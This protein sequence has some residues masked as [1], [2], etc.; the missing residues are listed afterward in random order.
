MFPNRGMKGESVVT[1]AILPLRFATSTVARAAI[2]LTAPLL[3]C[4][5]AAAFEEAQTAAGRNVDKAATDFFEQHVRPLFTA[6]CVE[7]H[8]GSEAEAGLRL[9][10]AMALTEGADTG[11]VVV[12]G[13]PDK[14]RLIEV[15]RYSGD[16]QMP[17]TEK[18]PQEQI[19]LLEEWVRKGAIWP[20]DT[21]AAPSTD[22]AMD[23]DDGPLG[24]A[25]YEKTKA[26]HWSLQP[27]TRPD[28]P[29][30]DG[31]D[32]PQSTIDRFVL[33]SLE[34]VGLTP[35]ARAD[36]RTL[37]RRLYFDVVGLPPS[38]D[39]VDAFIADDSPLA[40]ERVINRLLNSPHYGQRWGR[41]WL[42]VARYADTKGYA[43]QQE[44][45]YPFAYTYRDYV[46]RALNQ[47]LPFDRFIVEQIAA[48]LLL[49]EQQIKDHTSLAALGFLTVG[50]RFNFNV[51]DIIDDRIDVVTRGFMG[52]SVS[53]ARCHDHKYDPVPTADYYSLYG[54]FASSHEP[55]ELPLI[56][57]PAETEAYAAYV[58]ELK[59]REGAVGE[60]ENKKRQQIEQ[61][62]R[63]QVT[64][65][66]LNVVA[67]RQESLDDKSLS[68][69]AD[70]LRPSVLKGWRAYLKKRTKADDPVFG[71]WSY[72]AD[73][74]A[75]E[76][77][78]G[79][80][81]LFAN[82]VESDES[83][84]AAKTN[85][86]V[87]EHFR[88]ARPADMADVA[89]GYG[90]LLTDVDNRWTAA[91]EQFEAQR[92]A[93][94]EATPPTTLEDAA[95]EEMRQVLY[96]DNSP[97]RVSSDRLAGVLDRA[98][99][100][101]LRQLKKEVE[102]WKADSPA[103][104]A[105]AMVLVDN[106]KPVEPHVFLRGS[107]GRRGDQVTR[108]FLS[109]LGD[110]EV[111]PFKKG[112]G[113]LELAR[114]IASRDN[115]LTARVIVNRVWQQYFGKGLVRTSSDFGTRGELPS[116]PELLD[117]L[118]TALVDN[119][120]SLKW[121]HGQILNSATYQQASLDREA[122]LAADP[123]NRLLW[124]MNRKPLEFEP[125]RDAMLLVSGDLVRRVGGRSMNLLA[126]EPD[127]YRRAIYGFIDRQDLPNLLRAFNFASP[128]AS[129]AQRPTT[130]VPQQALF[131]MNSP[132]V[133]QRARRAVADCNLDDVSSDLH[134]AVVRLFRRI[135][136]R[137]PSPTEIGAAE[138]F[139]ASAH[140]EA[141]EGVEEPADPAVDP[142]QALSVWERLAQA[143]LMTNEFAFV[144]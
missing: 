34:N 122:C 110:P 139:V 130:V 138:L 8:A 89:R 40:V 36:R 109:A 22:V 45:R 78:A 79:A 76:F 17:P 6:H 70:D 134:E 81:R 73:L 23:P 117:H 66:L 104:P 75:D 105:R 71:L 28:V 39:E 48:D 52:L 108:H 65:Y 30:V 94:P 144:D 13:D 63:G 103:A 42:D 62:L 120:W 10:G 60:Y 135:L 14:S 77:A 74:P 129:E 85:K 86:L 46:I 126:L 142:A 114:A 35:S 80:E 95:A 18:L 56:A 64:Q 20:T 87:W 96:A 16:I 57:P 1:A 140:S 112:S 44:P 111:S 99:R 32:W 116:H 5:R 131:M 31:A 101:K 136:G 29:E 83:G 25:T 93:S 92:S 121:L 21:S 38:A 37:L 123:E 118:A 11:P 125:L 84:I 88:D 53:C 3:W 119:G 4:D 9:D 51:H 141:P 132:F 49:E 50:R 68:L 59:R 100:N 102:K 41:H 128:D 98:D 127:S 12:V 113:R 27:I 15:V 124:K 106:D 2:L 55:N 33:A 72:F 137:T 54:V 67:G 69:G 58:E 24:P 26:T 143:L 19:A 43:F 133:I 7:C 107:P 90:Q 115:P 61:A 97:T 82:A 47:D 91:L